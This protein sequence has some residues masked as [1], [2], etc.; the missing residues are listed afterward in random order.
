MN[1]GARQLEE[2]VV[3]AYAG[4]QEVARATQA[5]ALVV[6]RQNGNMGRTVDT[7]QTDVRRRIHESLNPDTT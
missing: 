1:I 4:E 2:E 5:R 7:T 6:E 3:A